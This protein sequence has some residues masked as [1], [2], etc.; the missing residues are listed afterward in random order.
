LKQEFKK[1]RF[2]TPADNDGAKEEANLAVGT[3][4]AGKGL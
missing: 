1:R 4:S 2:G 3:R